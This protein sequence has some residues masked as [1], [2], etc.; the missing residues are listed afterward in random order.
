LICLLAFRIQAQELDEN[1]AKRLYLSLS[2]GMGFMG[3]QSDIEDHMRAS[4]LNSR[5]Y[6]N[7]TK[8]PVVHFTAN[9][10]LKGRQGRQVA[11]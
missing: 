6:P 11:S 3:P 7:A 2:G 9:Y 1:Q 5:N 10:W 8:I 4:G